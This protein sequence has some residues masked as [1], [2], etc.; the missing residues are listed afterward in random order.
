MSDPL[1]GVI[2]LV[3]WDA[4][5]AIAEILG[6]LG[7]IATLAYLAIQIRQSTIS[8]RTSSYQAAVSASADFSRGLGLDGDAARIFASCSRDY[9]SLSSEERTRFDFLIASLF[10]NYENI[11]YQHKEGSIDDALWAGW[12]WRMRTTFATPGVKAWW[13]TNSSG[14]SRGFGVYLESTP[15]PGPGE[16]PD[17]GSAA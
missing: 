15:F 1:G 4:I 5:G 10:R 6:A 16:A 11:F 13:Q 7:V 12:A 17:P 8:T 14:Y 3:N 2:A 9:P